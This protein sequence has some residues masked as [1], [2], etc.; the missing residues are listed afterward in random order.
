VYVDGS[1]LSRYLAGAPA[2]EAWLAWTK[3]HEAELVTTPLGLTE[4]RR[5]AQPRGLDAHGTA[6]EVASRIEVARFSDQT[7]RKASSVTSVL[8]PFLALHLGAALAHPDVTAVATYDVKLARVAAIYG[9]RVV[10]PGWPD[11][12]WERDPTPWS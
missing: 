3:D 2:R 9:L 1:A 11:K 5:I 12:W 8:T 6:H 10:T 7:L 4:L